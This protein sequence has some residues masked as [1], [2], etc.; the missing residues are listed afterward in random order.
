MSGREDE[1]ALIARLFAPFA[2][3]APTAALGLTDDVAILSPDRIVTVDAIVENVHFRADDPIDTVAK[4]LVRVNVSDIV[5]KGARPDAALLALCWPRGR[6]IG[7]L[8]VFAQA[9]GDDLESFGVALIGGDTT[10]TDG[11]LTASLTLFGRPGPRGPVL[12]RGAQAGDLVFV[13]GV[14]GD[15][16]LGLKV[17]EGTLVSRDP[18][19]L[20][21]RYRSPQPRLEWSDAVARL[22]S[23]AIDISDGLWADAGHLAK[24][25]RV[26]IAIDAGAIP[27]SAAAREM[28]RD[29]GEG[30]AG[31]VRLAGAGDDYE[32]LFT[33]PV[34][35]EAQILAGAPSAGV[36]VTRIGRCMAGPPGAVSALGADG[37]LLEIPLRGW[38]HL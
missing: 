18:T 30:L 6:T 14:I 5:A 3:K 2:E 19:G 22:A 20:I 7:E 26:A 10:R 38:S 8:E 16:G 31:V 33:A 35:H 23:A 29:A 9:L 27:L 28:V 4:K 36:P 37:A 21:A 25:S 15:A 13:T 1:F 24:A 11:P 34:E 17:L 12:R 32:I